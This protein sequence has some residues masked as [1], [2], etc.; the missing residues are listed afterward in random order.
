MKFKEV[1]M[2]VLQ[3]RKSHAVHLSTVCCLILL[4]FC[5]GNASSQGIVK[6]SNEFLSIGVGAR[7]LGMSGAQTALSQDVHSGYWNPA[8]LALMADKTQ[9]ALMHSE[10][11]AGIAKYDYGA[12]ARRID[13]RTAAAVSVIRFGI[14]DIPDTSE[15]I[16]ASGNINYDRVTSFSAADFAFLLSVSRK[17]KTEGLSVGGNVKVIHRRI[18]DFARAWGFGID[19][20]LRYQKGKWIFAAMARDVSTTFNAWS[21]SLSE[22]QKQAFNATG[23]VIPVNSNEITVPSLSLGIARDFT[24]GK[25]FGI[26]ASADMQATFDGMRNTLVRNSGW[27][28]NPVAGLEANFKQLIFLRGGIGN[29]Q[30]VP[31]V[32]LTGRDVSYQ[33]N[34]GLGVKLGPVHVDYAFSDIGDRS[35]ALYSH[36]F[37]LKFALNPKTAEPAK[38]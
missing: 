24:L 33:P 15:L 14:D 36:V 25:R 23:N 3:A 1:N 29:F 38:P 18:G 35:T 30:S 28:M 21:F 6:Y 26:T 31:N 27:S 10:Y 7:A 4:V 5:S 2:Q 37:S 13:D 17:L 20:G 12:L 22:A 19:A 34:I 11:F 8:G 16:D 32:D 9:V